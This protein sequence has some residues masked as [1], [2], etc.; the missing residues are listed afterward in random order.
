MELI[1]TK[2]NSYLG[3]KRKW[4]NAIMS[5]AKMMQQLRGLYSVEI[6]REESIFLQMYML[7]INI[8]SLPVFLNIKL[9]K[10]TKQNIYLEGW[11]QYGER[12]N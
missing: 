6:H 5:D 11:R 3:G 9:Q 10:Q 2:Q 8:K 12:V 7:A 4:R 1:Q